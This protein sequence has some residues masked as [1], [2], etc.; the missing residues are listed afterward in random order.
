MMVPLRS[1]T[2]PRTSTPGFDRQLFLRIVLYA[3][4]FKIFV[5]LILPLGLDEAYATA[6]AREFS[7][8]FFDHPPVGFW[9]PV[10]SANLTGIEHKLIYRLPFLL[11]GPMTTW[12]MFLIGREIAGPRVGV[13]TAFFYE[14]APFFLFSAGIQAVPDGPM[15]LASAVAVFFLV[16]CANTDGRVP[17]RYWVFAGVALSFALA[18]KYQAAWI[19][20]A[21]LMFMITTRR[22]RSWFLQPGPWLAAALGFLG[23]VPVVIWN[24]NHDWASFT[25]HTSRAGQ[26]PDLSNVVQMTVGQVVFVLPPAIVAAAIGLGHTLRDRAD[27]ARIFLALVALGPIVIFNYIFLTSTG[28]HAHWALPGWQF[29]LPLGAVWVAGSSHRLQVWIYRATFGFLL[30][31]WT[32]LVVLTLHADTGFLTRPF[33]DHAPDW[34]YTLS[35][36]DF[37][38]LRAELDKRDLWTSTDV[39]M[40]SSWAFGGILDTALES[41]KPMR[42]S[43][44]V[45]AHHFTFLSDAKATGRTLYMGP[46]TLRDTKKTNARILRIA[47]EID[48]DAT[49]L[50]PIILNRGGVGYV[51]VTLVCLTLR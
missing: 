44:P 15:N 18:S 2:E 6:V 22:G 31:V 14:A 36:F 48:P 19:P 28:S 23:L 5:A 20:V 11:M 10:I 32:P 9:L 50:P 21:A 3:M 16:K 39:F 41:R 45:G 7:L 51:S 12:V 46:A 8:S 13:W 26:G 4:S 34:D 49:L 37:G 47:R 43:E 27:P 38:D 17:F 29:A 25:F 30:L 1:I 35:V 33:Y 24:L 40:A 42:I